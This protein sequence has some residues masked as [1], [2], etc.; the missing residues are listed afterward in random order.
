MRNDFMQ[1]S[2]QENNNTQYGIYNFLE[3]KYFWKKQR[4]SKQA[5]K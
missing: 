1:T 3:K 4:T 2:L 5:S